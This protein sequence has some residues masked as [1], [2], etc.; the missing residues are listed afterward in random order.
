MNI[1]QGI[2]SNGLKFISF[3]VPHTKTKAE[4]DTIN[5]SDSTCEC[6]AIN[7]LEHHLTS[8]TT[9][10][11]NAPLFAFETA[12]NSWSPMKQSWFIDRCDEIWREEGLSSVKGHGFRI[13]GTT[14]LL[15]L[16]VDPWIIMM[17]G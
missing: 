4:G 16:G 17:Q 12:D 2:T 7:A 11:I 15:L 8:N 10:L 13:G 5:M 1:T 14:H 6:S 9:I 3:G